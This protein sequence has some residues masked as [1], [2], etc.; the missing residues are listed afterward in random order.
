MLI[1]S[2]WSE[3]SGEDSEENLIKFNGEEVLMH[4]FLNVLGKDAT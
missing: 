4:T 3:E 2:S 1:K